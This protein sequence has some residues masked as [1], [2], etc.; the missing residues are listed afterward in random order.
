MR[1]ESVPAA[2]ILV[3]VM[4]GAIFL[5]GPGPERFLDIPGAANV[6]PGPTPT[7]IVVHN[8]CRWRGNAGGS[9]QKIKNC[10]RLAA[11]L[12]VRGWPTQP[13]LSEVARLSSTAPAYNNHKAAREM[14]AL[15]P[16]RT[17]LTAG[18]AEDQRQRMNDAEFSTER[19]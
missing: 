6:I 11:C 15:R 7:E 9:R 8:E 14:R 17:R 1:N 12:G 16:F 13:H 3:R 10:P 18:Q 4:V 19:K 2:V 5:V